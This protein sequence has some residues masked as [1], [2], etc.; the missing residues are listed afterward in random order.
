MC[1]SRILKGLHSSDIELVV[2]RSRMYVHNGPYEI[3]RQLRGA[4]IILDLLQ[5]FEGGK[6]NFQIG[7][8][9]VHCC[10]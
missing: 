3:L 4:T 7:R 5:E 1:I 10:L 6:V 9:Q 2:A 8:L